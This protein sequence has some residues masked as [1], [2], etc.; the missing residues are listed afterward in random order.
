MYFSTC[1]TLRKVIHDID[2][3]NT[4]LRWNA[5]LHRRTYSVPGPNSLWHFGKYELSVIIIT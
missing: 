2:P 3:I 4:A 1:E 5:K